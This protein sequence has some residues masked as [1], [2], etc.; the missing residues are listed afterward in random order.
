MIKQ[1]ILITMALAAG[2]ALPVVA[3]DDDKGSPQINKDST[4]TFRLDAPNAQEVYVVGSFLPKKFAVKTVAGT[5]GKDDKAVMVK[6]GKTWTFTTKAL[7]SELYTYNF[8]VDGIE[9]TDPS[10]VNQL[11]DIDQYS[12]YFVIDGAVG[13]DYLTHDVA[14]GTVSQLW[15]PSSLNG[16]TQRRLTVYTPAAYSADSISRYPVLYL[17]HGSGGDETAWVNNGRAAQ[18]L[19]NLIASGR[20]KPMIVVMPNGIAELDAAPGDGVDPQQQPIGMSVASMTGMVEKA[21]VPEIVDFIDSRYR[22]IAEKSSRA[23][24]GLSLGGLHTLYTSANNPDVFAYVG[25]FSAQTT[26][27]LTDGRIKRLGNMAKGLQKVTTLLPSLK[28]GSMGERMEF[29]AQRFNDGSID[30]YASL[31]DKLKQ[32]FAAGVSLYYIALGKDD[33]VK[34]LNDDFRKRLDDGGYAYVYHE[35]D[36]GHSW[37][38]WRKYLVDFLPRLF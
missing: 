25:L 2:L 29:M 20:A 37:E 22:T 14:H 30:V 24:A 6:S 10:N 16:A 32:Q 13:G 12:S 3:A 4:V 21:F 19:D 18:I 8:V 34:K 23:I 31:D 5:F 36:G 7:A 9:I 15:Y 33:F 27:A 35:T 38:N 26:N 1:R 17:L 28:K 11:R